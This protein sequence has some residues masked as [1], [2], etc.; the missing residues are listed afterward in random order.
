MRINSLEQLIE[1]ARIKQKKRIAV[2]AAS[3]ESVLCA[4]NNA[5]RNNIIEPLL[6]GNK[7]EIIKIST[8]KGYDISE[9]NIIDEKDPVQAVCIAVANIRSGNADILMKGMV[10]TAP[11]LKAVLDKTNGLKKNHILSHFTL[12]K[13]SYYH[14]LFA[15]SDAAMNISPDLNEKKIIIENAVEIFHRLGNNMPKVAVLSPLETV[16]EKIRS[17]VDASD[18]KEL[19]QKG[20][21]TGCIVDGP[22]ALDNAVSL[23]AAKKKNI[24][25]PVA[26]DADLLITPDLN[27]GNILY[28]CLTFLSDAQSAAIITGATVPIVL[29]SR[30]DNEDIKLYSIALAAVL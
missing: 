23:D 7:S 19:N 6:I 5:C 27:S 22:L 21:I 9:W 26:G 3:D 14:K 12:F 28:K 20:I 1:I 29:T 2:A 30:A 24:N 25:S 13:S 8:L 11:L 17:T 4:I 16:N 15:I 10:S 18:L